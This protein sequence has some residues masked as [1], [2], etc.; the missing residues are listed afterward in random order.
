M[1]SECTRAQKLVYYSRAQLGQLHKQGHIE[2]ILSL[3]F[4]YMFML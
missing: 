2:K 3:A 4:A 1:Q